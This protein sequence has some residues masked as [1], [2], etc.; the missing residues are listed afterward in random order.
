METI[1]LTAGYDLKRIAQSWENL[2][3]E[4]SINLGSTLLFADQFGI[5]LPL[6]NERRLN[7]F[8]VGGDPL[9][10]F[11]MK[12]VPTDPEEVYQALLRQTRGDGK[13]DKALTHNREAILREWENFIS[14]FLAPSRDD[15]LDLIDY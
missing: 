14:L 12:S 6:G 4:H 5:E 1:D 10:Y 11:P 3:A 13:E 9:I 2:S 8:I 15:S 7:L